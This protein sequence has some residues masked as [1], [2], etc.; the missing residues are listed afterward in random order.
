MH[1]LANLLI[2]TYF[3]QFHCILIFSNNHFEYNSK[4]PIVSV[5][6][7]EKIDENVVF[8]YHGCQGI[9]ISCENDLGIFENFEF[10]LKSNLERFNFRR[11]LIFGGNFEIFSSK[12][13]NYV[14]DVVMVSKE[15]D[16][17]DKFWLGY[18]SIFGMYTHRYVGEKSQ[19]EI[20]LLD[21]WFLKNQSFSFNFNLYLDKL[22]DQ[23]GRELKIATFN[24]EPYSIPGNKDGTEMLV[25]LEFAKRYKMTPTF[26]VD[27]VGM[28]GEIYDNWTGIGI[29]GNLAMDKGD[30]GIGALYTWEHDF[31]F[32]D[33]TK[34]TIRTGVTCIAPKPKIIGGWITPFLAFSWKLWIVLIIAI[35]IIFSSIFYVLTFNTSKSFLQENLMKSFILTQS[36]FLLQSIPKFPSNSRIIFALSLLLSLMTATLY[37]SGL[38]SIMTVPRYKGTI[39][40]V[41]DLI[42]SDVKWGASSYAWISSLYDDNSDVYKEVVNNFYKGSPDDLRK[43]NNESFAFAIE[44]LHGGH[45][46]IG[47]YI[48]KEGIQER[49]LMSQDIYWDYCIVMLRKSSILTPKFDNLILEISQTGLPSFWEYQ[50]SVR[51]SDM[52]LQEAVHNSGHQP[53]SSSLIKL[54][55]THLEG[56]FA[57]WILGIIISC[58]AFLWELRPK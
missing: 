13:I 36:I 32:L 10:L 14:A 25:V 20:V 37:N 53:H 29:L 4:I 2:S 22:Q 7:D 1:V 35:I 49:R 19:R 38:A 45:Y 52:K 41:Y 54:S 47:E 55:F 18:D 15:F 57:L 21:K 56:A 24:Y 16:F 48:T 40:D 34:P 42:K 26:L 8:K 3:N 17:D 46:A 9:V 28:W 6:C 39:D 5:G 44:R 33:F 50:V 30:V 27:D 51:N 43:R 11:Y 31:H 58:I 12:S 23:N